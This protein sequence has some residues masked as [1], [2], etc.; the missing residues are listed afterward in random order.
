MTRSFQE[1]PGSIPIAYDPQHAA[2]VL[3]SLSKDGPKALADENFRKL[4]EAAA[5]NSPYLARVMLREKSFLGEI[6]NTPPDELLVALNNEALGIAAETDI[7]VAMRRLRVAKR[8]AALTIALADIAGLYD[9]DAVTGALT[10]FADAALKG[11]LRHLLRASAA[12]TDFAETPPQELE[13]TKGL[14]VLAMGKHGAFEL[15]YSSDIDIVVFY[16]EQRFPFLVGREKRRAAV[17][18]V[19]GIVKLLADVTSDGYVFR[20]DLRLRPDAGATQVAISTEAGEEYY[21]LMGQNWERAAMIKARA[22]AGD[23]EA[24]GLFQKN[25]LPF[26]WRK[27]LDFASI[28]DIHSIKRQIHTH[29]GHGVVA[30]A[31]HNLKL[32]RGGIREIEFFAQTQQLIL[33]GRDPSLRSP[34]TLEA[35]NALETRGVISRAAREELSIAYDFLRKV[36]HRL[37]MIEDQQ[38]HELPKSDEALDRVARFSGF[39][40]TKEFKTEVL[41]HLRKVESNYAQL[42]EQ[43]AP[44]AAEGGSLVFTGVDDDPNTIET[45]TNMGF[46]GPSIIATAIRGWHHGRIRAT[47]TQRSREILTRLIPSLLE[48]LSKSADPQNAFVHFDRFISGLPGGVQ[49]FS[50]LLAHPELLTL[51]AEIAGSAPR[52]AEYLGRNAGA[53]DALI[54]PDFLTKI[55]EHEELSAKFTN[56]RARFVGFEGALDAARR[57]ARE[58]MFRIGVQVIQ[59][60]TEATRAGPAY[61]AIAETII[62]NLQPVVEADIAASHGKLS[63]GG[64]VVLALGKLGGREM[65]AGSD[66]DLVF[67]YSHDADAEQSDGPR[68]LAPG[69]YYAR[70]S[71]RFISALTA[72][73]TEGQ[74]YEVDM[75]LRPSGNQGPVAV[76]LAS[77]DEYHAK[78]SWTW[79][80]MALTRARILS[81]PAELAGKVE[82]VIGRTL[83]NST[84]TKAIMRDA[85]EMRGKIAAQFPGKEMWDLKFAPG[86]LVD[87]EFITQSLQ[88]C[89]AGR[90][91]ILDQNTIK[92]IKKLNKANALSGSDTKTLI[93]AASLQHVL[94]QVLRIALDG[95]FK[96]EKSSAGLKALLVRAAKADDFPSLEAQ[97]SAAQAGVCEIFSRIFC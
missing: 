49:V 41:K 60:K 10:R 77:F 65:T 24:A 13:E 19:K 86:G 94:M 4:L 2:D 30:V 22:C 78:K 89:H 11:A 72:I 66:L 15:N 36:E 92:A 50:L 55:P 33:G 29:G 6:Q 40:D 90:A 82:R 17:E 35:L 48:A 8:K 43:E 61:A 14:F 12:G 46:S 21:E 88:L 39:G 9:L 70:T 32:G 58:E 91:D 57:F 97:L 1:I 64:F 95:P 25:L 83:T 5:G 56:E 42:F 52:L 37:Q 87:L 26:I 69:Q 45:L 47:R 68:P 75:R 20:V 85:F 54:D 28:E 44:L 79:E 59:G 16:E 51:I 53:L 27:Y 67:V 80:R 74:L 63:G 81:G 76:S 84:E 38:T 71:Q 7:K 18:I 34:R 31:G 96:P 73:T 3:Q 23:S 62:A 93:E